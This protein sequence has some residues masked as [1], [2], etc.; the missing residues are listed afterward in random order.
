MHAELNAG[1]NTKMQIHAQISQILH[2]V[3]IQKKNNKIQKKKNRD[4]LFDREW[5]V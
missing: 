2:C 1:F 5:C 4:L 3:Y